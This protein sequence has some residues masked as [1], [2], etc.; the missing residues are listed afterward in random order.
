M[1]KAFLPLIEEAIKKNWNNQALSNYNANTYTYA[2]VAKRFASFKLLMQD[3][4]IAQGEKI[5]LLS[6]NSAEWAM[7]LIAILLSGNVAVPILSDFSVD[8]AHHI[9]D[10][11]EAKILIVSSAIWSKLN[12]EEMPNLEA[13]LNVDNLEIFYKKGATDDYD[14]YKAETLFDE[15]YPRGIKYEQLEFYKEKPEDVALINYTSGTS[16]FSK[17]V[18]LPYRSLWNNIYYA[19]N[20]MPALTVGCKL[21]SILP[22]AHMY[23]LAFELFFPFTGGCH[24]YFL[25][26]KPNPKMLSMALADIKPNLLLC[27]PLII[28]KVVKKNVFPIIKTKKFKILSRIPIINTFIYKTIKRKLSEGFGGNFSEV[29]IGG[30]A[31]NPDVEALLRKIKFPYTVGYGMTECGPLV[32]YEDWDAVAK[33]S[34]GKLVDRMEVRIDSEDKNKAGEI[35]L[36]GDS[37]ML[38]YYK[39]EEATRNAFTEDGWLRTGDLGVIDEKGF[40]YIKGR[41]KNMLLGPNGQNIYPEEIEVVLNNM[42][43]VSECLAV[44]RDNKLVALIYPEYDKIRQDGLDENQVNNI[45]QQNIDK[46]NETHERYMMLASFELQKEEFQKTPKHSIKR[47]LYQ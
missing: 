12:I 40:L 5:A 24:I 23:G 19:I 31:L 1:E 3:M 39:N 37:V 17:G 42:P 10:H 30:A 15:K 21:L 9:V 38:G 36:K 4:G 20:K 43:Y 34:V 14:T 18:M 32:T 2:D 45:M 16:G 25:K 29:I 44:S 26:R 22:L 35:L 28:E 27:V 11:S 46:Y 7:D 47:Y 6:S 33:D 8:S 13:V 41:C